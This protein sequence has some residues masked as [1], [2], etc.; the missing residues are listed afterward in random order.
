MTP[1]LV[2]ARHALVEDD[3]RTALAALGRAHAP[4]PADRLL[5][6]VA[7][8]RLG[9]FAEATRALAPLLTDPASDEAVSAPLGALLR[10]NPDVFRG[11]V[12][13]AVGPVQMR[14]RL[15]DA[16]RQALKMTPD[17]RNVALAW[18]G[19]AERDLAT[20]MF[21]ILETHADAADAH[22]SADVVKAD[23]EAALLA[24]DDESRLIRPLE[25]TQRDWITMAIRIELARL[26]AVA[27]DLASA[28][29]ELQ[30]YAT[31]PVLDPMFVDRLLAH[32]DLR[33]L[34]SL[35]DR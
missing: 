8:A 30:P 4:G 31:A 12:H 27:G 11:L 6:V 18:N 17:S 14:L 9:R 2:A 10:N 13:D 3:P 29:R 15:S 35:V 16:V 5:G 21:S 20:D 23:W 26:A 32:D 22:G 33:P 7:L 1:E 25:A 24:L 34:W 28:E 19:L